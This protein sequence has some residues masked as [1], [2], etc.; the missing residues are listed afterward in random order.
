MRSRVSCSRNRYAAANLLRESGKDCELRLRVAAH[1]SAITNLYPGVRCELI[2]FARDPVEQ[3]AHNIAAPQHKVSRER[4][5]KAHKSKRCVP[6]DRVNRPLNAANRLAGH[7]WRN[8]WS[9]AIVSVHPHRQPLRGQKIESSAEEGKHAS[10][11]LCQSNISRRQPLEAAETQPHSRGA[12]GNGRWALSE[13]ERLPAIAYM[14][15]Q[16]FKWTNERVKREQF[17]R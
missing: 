1:D 10:C 8:G 14:E 4:T 16:K 3:L 9:F 12:W 13:P 5:R 11:F 2:R 7:H 6:R 17:V 15:T